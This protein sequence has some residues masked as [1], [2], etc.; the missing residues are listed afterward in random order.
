MQLREIIVADD[1]KGGFKVSFWQKPSAGSEPQNALRQTLQRI[2]AG[3]ILLLRNIALNT[4]RDNVY[5]QSLNLSIARVQTSV[6]VLMSGTGVSSRQLGALP[7]PVVTAFM[8]VKKWANVHV[9]SDVHRKRKDESQISNR[10]T[11][12]SF[13]S[14]GNYDEELPP[15]TM[16]PI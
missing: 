6:Q 11:K 13:R 8:R 2:K 15:D 7:A 12:R 1:T 3:D 4:F 16:E 9:A 14:V 5:G 10:S